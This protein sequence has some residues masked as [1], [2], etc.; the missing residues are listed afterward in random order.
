MHFNNFRSHFIKLMFIVLFLHCSAKGQRYLSPVLPLDFT[1]LSARTLAMGGGMDFHSHPALGNFGK[2]F[3]LHVDLDARSTSETR[4][5]P[6]IDMFDDVVTENVYAINRS[7]NYS[8]P[9][10]LG[11]DATQW[12]K[13]PISLSLSQA[14]MW[15]FRYNYTEEVRASLGPGVYNRDPVAGY[16]IFRL[17]GLIQ[18]THLNMAVR[19][20]SILG[21]G[22]SIE[23]LTGENLSQE[24]GVQVLQS[25]EALAADSTTMTQYDLAAEEAMRWSAGIIFNPTGSVSIGISM[26]SAVDISFNTDGYVPVLDERTQLPGLVLADTTSSYSIS[27]PLEY[28]IG[29]TARLRNRIKTIASGNYTYT[30]WSNNDQVIVNGTSSDTSDFHYQPTWS[31]HLGVEH[32]ILN[33]TPFRFGFMH[34]SS[35]LGDDFE[36]TMITLGTGRS[37]GHFTFDLAVAFESSEYRYTDL[38]IP[39]GQAATDLEKVK[40][41]TLVVKSSLTYSF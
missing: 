14:P 7:L 10:S 3:K 31:I 38:F 25:D 17:S 9:W 36:R 22:F 6:V 34:S 11:I 4:S 27:L 23:S 13:I 18:S 19:P 41:S 29:F 33:K 2:G 21:F 32:W 15:D 35:P 12:L 30:D 26:K 5:F 1:Q 16:H 28:G 20:L 37:F 8:L 39:V 24:I 40:E